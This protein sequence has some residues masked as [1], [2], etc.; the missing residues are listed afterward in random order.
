MHLHGVDNHRDH[1]SLDRLP[2]ADATT[3]LDLLKMFE[4]V[5]SL[6]VFS[7]DHLKASL[8]FLDDQRKY[9]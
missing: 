4:G 9:L 1:L 2:V 6:E 7:F 5:V 3:V 8:D